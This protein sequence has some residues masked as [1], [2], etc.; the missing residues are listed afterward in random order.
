MPGENYKIFP[1]KASP[2]IKRD[3]TDT[4][5][6]YWSQ[7][8]WVR[9]YRG[10]PRSMLG[11]RS[12]SEVF[13]GPSRGLLVNPNGQ[14]YL[15]IFS[16]SASNLVVGQFT[17]MGVGSAYTDVT[18][19]GYTAS[20]NNVWQMD[21]IY[22]PQGSGTSMIFAHS[23]PNLAAIDS[24]ITM[25]VYYG[26]VNG[27]ALLTAAQNDSSATF[28]IDGGV[29][30]MP[31]LMVAYGSNGLFCWSQITGSYNPA[32]FPVAN[33]ANICATKIV[34]GL[35]I[36][37]GSYNPSCL[38]WSLDSL[39]QASYVG[40]TVVWNFNTLSDQSSILS[41]SG[42]V[43]M[44]GIYYWMG[45]DRFLTFSGVLKELPNE[46]NLDFCFSNLN[47]AQRQKAF[48]FK[49]P[50]WGEIWFCVPLFGSTECNWAIIYNVRENTWYDTPLP[51][52]G[53]SA[54]YFAQTWNYPVLSSAT[55]LVPIGQ[56]TGTNYP[57]YQHNF[58]NDFIRGNQVNAIDS[59]ILSPSASLVGGNL[60]FWA[61]PMGQQQSFQTQLAFFEQD[62][63]F[64]TSMILT[65]Y[66][67][68]YAQDTDTVLNTQTITK[69]ATG[70]IFDLQC[71]SRYLRWKL[72]SNTQG[73]SFIM[74]SPSIFYRQG[75]PTP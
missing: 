10:L 32:V 59:W 1:L 56:N 38:L 21:L 31:P 40:G 62:F 45:I 5:G 30:A 24:N 70:N 67:R 71:Q 9:F 64:G 26:N 58:G 13:P 20:P 51:S 37:G 16:G 68:M 2:G 42:V 65:T 53:R 43:E 35:L 18:P 28:S 50:A 8:Q 29:L 11:Y 39:I 47:Y 3:T 74:G 6:N 55:G 15:N 41:S 22:D 12:M 36:R 48:A 19:S 61:S 63:I 46:M 34:K 66:G 54:A 23:A 7:G 44:D 4:E 73:G 14:G 72:E 60:S 57:I 49:S 27:T 17:N 69:Q 25:P 52:D 75:D 33:A